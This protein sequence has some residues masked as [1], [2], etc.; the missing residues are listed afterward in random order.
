MKGYGLRM[1]KLM[2]Y[3]V[4]ILRKLFP[5]PIVTSFS[6]KLLQ[7]RDREGKKIIESLA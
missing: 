3:S 6:R 7:N 5:I 4:L 2:I 1:W